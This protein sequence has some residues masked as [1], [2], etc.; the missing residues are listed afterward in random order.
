MRVVFLC[1]NLFLLPRIST[2]DLEID[3]LGGRGMAS[4]GVPEII[5]SA[6][7]TG[8]VHGNQPHPTSLHPIGV[9]GVVLTT[10]LSCG[11]GR[12]G[13]LEGLSRYCQPAVTVGH[14]E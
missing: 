7:S 9:P 12:G 5:R 2:D 14:P 11:L 13:R 1:R 6:G 10:Q 8:H 4:A 3:P